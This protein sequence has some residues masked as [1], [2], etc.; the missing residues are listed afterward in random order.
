VTSEFFNEILETDG[1][2]IEVPDMGIPIRS[3]VIG[4]ALVIFTT[5]GIWAVS[6]GFG[7]S[8]KPT[9][10]NVDQI[11]KDRVD[12][13]LSILFVEDS[14]YFWTKSG[15]KVLSPGQSPG[16]W[17][18]VSLTDNRFDSGYLELLADNVSPTTV[19]G[20]YDRYKNYLEWSYAPS[21]TGN[22]WLHTK[23]LRYN[24]KSGAF[25]KYSFDPGVSSLR[26]G[27]AI[28]NDADPNE[29]HY[30]IRS[31]SGSNLVISWSKPGSSNFYD[32]G[33]SE[34]DAYITMWPVHVGAPGKDKTAPYLTT[35]LRKTE[36]N[37]TG[38]GTL[39]YP[40]G[41][42]ATVWWDYADSNGSEYQSGPHNIY[43]IIN[44]PTDP[45][46]GYPVAFDYPKSIIVNKTK[47]RGSG[48]S[49]Q[50]KIESVDTKDFQFLGWS[51]PV[52]VET[53]E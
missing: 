1:G 46:S 12:A 38:V 49:F 47:V 20:V 2:R 21:G 9:A 8:F 3:G 45:G 24:L 22:G 28:N 16:V 36:E 15:I 34:S 6:G 19:R 42:T 17:S 41:A 29:V 13:P 37:W 32:Y 33:M 43:R 11:S 51:T 18:I 5:K 26:L 40:S 4:S 25:T 14:V 10:L 7:E 27:G 44:G 39:D 50:L 48:K 31:V 52:Y 23:V 53:G 30:M 35:F